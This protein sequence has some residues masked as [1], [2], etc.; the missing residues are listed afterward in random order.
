MTIKEL[1]SYIDRVLGSSLRC[2]LPSYWWKRLFG[3]LVDKVAE[4]EKSVGKKQEQLISGETIKTI[5][6]EDILGGGNIEIKSSGVDVVVDAEL[7]K[8]SSNPIANKAVANALEDKASKTYVTEEISKIEIPDAVEVDTELSENSTNAIANSAVTAALDGKQD[9]EEVYE[10]DLGECVWTN[11]PVDRLEAALI[12]YGRPQ[13]GIVKVTGKIYSSF[14]NSDVFGPA[15]F[16]GQCSASEFEW[17]E[18]GKL[19]DFIPDLVADNGVVYNIKQG[20]YED[21]LT[22]IVKKGGTLFIGNGITDSSVYSSYN[23]YLVNEG[24]VA[25]TFS[26][27]YNGPA[28]IVQP[29]HVYKWISGI[30]RVTVIYNGAIEEWQIT[31]TF[32]HGD[33]ENNYITLAY[34]TPQLISSVPIGS[35]IDPSNFA[36]KDELNDKQDNIEDL[37][38]IRSGAALGATAIQEVKTINGQSIVGSGNIEIQG[39]G[40]IDVDTELSETSENPIANKAVAEV[41]NVLGA[42]FTNALD[43]R[44]NALDTNKANKTYVDEKMATKEELTNLTNEMV[45]NEEVHAAVYA[46]LDSRLRDIGSLISGVAVTKEEFQEGLQSITD[47]MVANEEVVAAALNEI[48]NRIAALEAKII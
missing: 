45:A 27:A 28:N 36:T 21:Y 39:G 1:K 5:N 13:T 43:A 3:L 44:Y 11:E 25:E 31:P 41:I 33:E 2:L 19:R 15:S 47:E 40:K 26:V 23:L 10:I 35:D 22:L 32:R 48:N 12:A 6:G 7:D 42:E 38:S 29:L 37:D 46:D 14:Q 18:N 17:N 8:T 30:I 20:V 34:A 9:K 16:S 24:S 4:V